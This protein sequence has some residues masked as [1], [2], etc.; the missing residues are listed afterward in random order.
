VLG[1]AKYPIPLGVL[2]P[3]IH[4]D[5][6]HVLQCPQSPLPR[7]CLLILDFRENLVVDVALAILPIAAIVWV[8]LQIVGFFT[9]VLDCDSMGLA[10]LGNLLAL[11]DDLVPL[12]AILKP[13]L[14][15]DGIK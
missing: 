3:R 2:Q 15:S 9:G 14:Q 13:R 1:L 8:G 11:I 12:P 5:G 6:W 7:F 4:Y 10:L